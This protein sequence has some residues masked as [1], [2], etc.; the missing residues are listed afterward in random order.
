[1]ALSAEQK[2]FAVEELDYTEAE[3]DAFTEKDQ[4]RIA[5]ALKGFLRQTD[6]SKSMNDLN[7]TRETL[8]AAEAKLNSEMADWAEMTTAER[9]SAG[10]L[11]KKLDDSEA[12]VFQLTQKA[13]R[14][15]EE[16]GIDPKTIIGDEPPP[17]K[18]EPETQAVDLDPLRNQINGFA[19]YMLDLSAILPAIQQEHF[20][21]TG[22]RLDTRKFV[23]DIKADLRTGKKT[24]ADLDPMAR[25]EREY[26]I[27]DIRATKQKESRDAELKAAREEGRT[28]AL[29]EAALPNTSTRPGQHAP[30][31]RTSNVAEG[32]KLTRPQPGAKNAS[33]VAALATGK[34]RTGNKGA[35]A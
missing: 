27:P 10:D 6:Y 21:L 28:Q 4:G 2:K 20:E 33:A 18:K 32:S 16:A 22:T 1:M 30:V 34:Y 7:T 8:T 12:R 17:K 29:S 25:W 31:F 23:A 14:L 19:D 35:A 15:A 13:T 3:A 24:A 26:K 5:K 11:R 9:A